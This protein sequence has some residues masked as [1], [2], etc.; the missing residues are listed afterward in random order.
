MYYAGRLILHT[1]ILVLYLYVRDFVYDWM[2]VLS[3]YYTSK[4][5]SCTDSN[6]HMVRS[7]SDYVTNNFKY[8]MAI[9]AF[10]RD[11]NEYNTL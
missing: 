4:I 5:M 10:A 7:S 2:I 1:N 8:L 11:Y 6:L 9:T 3:I